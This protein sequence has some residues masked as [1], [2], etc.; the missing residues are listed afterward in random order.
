MATPLAIALP[1]ARVR[2]PQAT[3]AARRSRPTGDSA[4]SGRP[5]I[6]RGVV[7]WPDHLPVG[8]GDPASA[9]D[10]PPPF[11]PVRGPLAR[12]APRQRLEAALFGGVLTSML[13]LSAIGFAGVVG[14]AVEHPAAVHANAVAQPRAVV[15]TRLLSVEMSAPSPSRSASAPG[16]RSGG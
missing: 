9:I 5:P 7:S 4:M 2:N 16:A 6:P 12:S 11:M 13:V 14:A 10:G 8:A 15:E 1:T 3:A